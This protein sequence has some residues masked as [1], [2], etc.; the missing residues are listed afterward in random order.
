VVATVVALITAI[1][2]SHAIGAAAVSAPLARTRAP[3]PPV[4]TIQVADLRYERQPAPGVWAEL[5]VILDNPLPGEQA[6]PTHTVLLVPGAFFEE[7][8]I[9]S[10]EPKLLA[11]PRLRSDGRYAL[12]FPAP[13]ALS[14]NWYRLELVVSRRATPPAQVSI[15]LDQPLYETRSKVVAVHYADRDADPFRVVPEPLVGW[16][17]GRQGS[18][19]PL[20][21]AYTLALAGVTVVGCAAAFRLV[22]R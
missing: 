14:L 20:L 16:L 4:P 19:L 7:F 8:N 17:P 6:S 1:A 11:P 10:T 22:R 18:A 9:R 13:L 12:L 2:L 5:K 15:L 21:L 3:A